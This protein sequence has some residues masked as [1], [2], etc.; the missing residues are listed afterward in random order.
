[1]LDRMKQA[2]P[3]MDHPLFSSYIK[4]SFVT[5]VPKYLNRDTFLIHVVAIFM[6][7]F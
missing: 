2:L 1:V 4:F 6:S 7:R 3:E 5:I